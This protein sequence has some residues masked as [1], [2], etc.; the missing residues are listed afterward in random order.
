LVQLPDK[1][2]WEFLPDVFGDVE[3]ISDALVIREHGL[4]LVT[5]AAGRVPAGNGRG[6]GLYFADT[7]HLS[8]FDFEINGAEPVVL[9]ST[10]DAGFYEEQVL[11]NSKA[12]LPDG[13]PV[14]RCT[15]EFRR[16]RILGDGLE[17]T[18]Q[19]TNYNPFPVGLRVTYHF[20]ADF[21]DIF[22]VRGHKRSEKGSLAEP[23]ADEQSIHYH[24]FGLD[25]VLRQ[26]RIVFE[27]EP[28]ELTPSLAVFDLNI[29][30]HEVAER[31]FE[32]AVRSASVDS[33]PAR[34]KGFQASALEHDRW[35]SQFASIDT[36]NELF[37][38]VIDR[39]LSDLRCLLSRDAR[40][41]Q[42]F[43]AGTPWFDTL[44][45]RDSIITSLQ[46]L[47]FQPDLTRD[48]LNLLA[49][50][51]GQNIDPFRAE[52][53]GRILHELRQ[54]EL[55]T[56]GE[57]PYKRYY[58][59]VDS[60][61]LFLILAGEY[62][63]WTADND[64]ISALR[65]AI[66]HALN[67][68]QT[69]GAKGEDGYLRYSTDA[70]SGL[71]NQGWKDSE[72]A[73]IHRD[74][75]YCPGP[76]ALAEVQGY[77]F[78]AYRSTAGLFEALHEHEEAALLL[79][80]AAALGSRFSREFWLHDDELLP[81]AIDGQG[82]PAAVMTSNAGQVLYSGILDVERAAKVKD[83]LLANDMFTGWGIRT[84]T[85][86]ATS[87]NPVGYHVGS[88][89]PHDNA[90]IALGFKRYGFDDEANEIATALFDAA[91]AFPYYR[92]PELF[93]GQP[94]APREPP[95][96][97]PV[98]CRPQA[99]A[100]GS[101]LQMIEAI[102]GLVPDAPGHRLN[103]VRPRLPYWLNRVQVRRLRVGE[104]SVDLTF[105]REHGATRVS[106]DR[107]DGIEVVRRR[108]WPTETAIRVMRAPVV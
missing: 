108:S 42:Y 48:C 36:D 25:G 10:A 32:I 70:M 93:G 76:I 92:L 12:V 31:R 53:P 29:G 74:G 14:G 82:R 61:P 102:L 7:R 63:R 103:I 80:S 34:S 73:I 57:L 65:P 87:F 66:S 45:G 52:E 100:S 96:P 83:R 22:E 39:S 27:Q 84:L 6:L 86:E 19:V 33:T 71:R 101:T 38:A 78:A 79:R 2:K 94:R 56:M 90:L 15:V 46:T 106:V 75:S 55:S 95:V 41:H 62:Y 40:G 16:Q 58:G 77:L 99:W 8:E 13:T 28:D 98:A 50:Y 4:F 88:V 72:N 105:T 23:K 11:G 1:G 44:F 97:Y 26:T 69:Y 21:A 85:N 47:P 91:C 51:Q 18:L 17:E 20:N 107:S 30:P 60:T 67:W 5:D 43:A 3:S 37:N 81:L 59:S 24:Y 49:W 64:T 104:G 54:D 68:I 9:L 35:K 89:W